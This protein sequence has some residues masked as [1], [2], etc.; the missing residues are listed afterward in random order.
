MATRAL[1]LTDTTIGRKM[2]MAVTGL[3]L[4][5]FVIVHMLGNLQIFISA[6]Q[7]NQ[8]SH[9][10]QSNKTLLWGTR[11]VLLLAVVAHAVTAVQLTLANKKARP[12][13]YKN[14]K[15]I[16]TSYA[17]KAMPIGGMVI[18]LYILFHLAHLTIASSAPAIAAGLGYNHSPLTAS[19][20]PD[21]YHN[22]VASFSVPWLTGIYLV[23]QCCL[24]LH[25]YHGAWS[26]FQSLGL[27]HKR[28]NT[29][30]RSAASALALVVV[31]GFA[32]VPIAVL[33]G[34]VK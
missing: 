23:A 16:A 19:G 25:L 32:A 12:V 2:V 17:A 33:L 28:Y 3:I 10:L 7:F 27:N 13:G 20:V 21:V 24:G 14:K 34:F 11:L 30:L 26:I 1:K 6:E 18:L 31:T 8:Y 9:M 5:G 29:T 4:F 22:V 15:D